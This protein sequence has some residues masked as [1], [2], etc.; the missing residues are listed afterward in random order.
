[1]LSVEEI[2][3]FP[4]RGGGAGGKGGSGSSRWEQQRQQQEAQERLAVS[5]AHDRLRHPQGDHFT[6][7]KLFKKYEAEGKPN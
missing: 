7:L 1:M 6:Y 4:K 2:F 5:D 3:H